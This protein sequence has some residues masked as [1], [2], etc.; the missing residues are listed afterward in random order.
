MIYGIAIKAGLTEA[1]A[2]DVLQETL[3]AVCKSM[4]T[5]QYD[6]KQGSFKNWLYRLTTSKITDQLRQRRRHSR[7]DELDAATGADFD[8]AE[9]EAA[10][11]ELEAVW[12]KE[13]EKHLWQTALERVKQK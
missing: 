12:D 11:S 3:L 4:P 6:S 2:Q 8:Q 10:H 1:D 5:F 7:E 9:D 13:W